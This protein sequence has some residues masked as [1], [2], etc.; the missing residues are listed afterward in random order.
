MSNNIAAEAYKRFAEDPERRYVA[1][2]GSLDRPGITSLLL[3]AAGYG[4]VY[5]RY[6]WKL[7]YIV[8]AGRR[9]EAD[10]APWLLALA[11]GVEE[12]RLQPL[13]EERTLIGR[14]VMKLLCEIL[15]VEQGVVEAQLRPK[16]RKLLFWR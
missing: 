4:C 1:G 3:R 10:K 14:E 8:S 16:R 7:S 9:F 12:S 5:D 15:D 6:A 2:F 13:F 11:F